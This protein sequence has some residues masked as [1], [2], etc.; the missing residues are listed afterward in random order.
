M[1][2][3]M[4]PLIIAH[5]LH[6][7]ILLVLLIQHHVIGMTAALTTSQNQEIIKTFPFDMGRSQ[8]ERSP[9]TDYT[10]IYREQREDTTCIGVLT[11]DETFGGV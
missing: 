10:G 6:Q 9:H 7:T 3:I 1:F 8:I 11:R 5:N 2:E 4:F